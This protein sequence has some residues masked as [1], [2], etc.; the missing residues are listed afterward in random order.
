[1]NAMTFRTRKGRKTKAAPVT[2][3]AWDKGAEGP[4]NQTRL[5]T[6]P[7]TEEDKDTGREIRTGGKRKRR[8]TWVQ[9]YARKGELT[10]TQLLAAERLARAAAGYPDRDP[11]AAVLS[12]KGTDGFDPQA[13]RVDA[14]DEFRRLWAGVLGSSKPVLQRVV[15]EDQPIWHGNLSQRER[16]MQ[17][18][19]DGLDAI[20]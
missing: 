17:R 2:L 16:H 7:A 13:A 18:L 3:P 10:P 6:E 1:M 5:C 11:L 12:P 4:A 20:S 14:R 8:Q 15:L 19:R 9:I